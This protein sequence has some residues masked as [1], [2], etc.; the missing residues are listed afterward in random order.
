LQSVGIKTAF[1]EVRDPQKEIAHLY[2]M[3]DTGLPADQGESVSSNEKR[4]ILRQNKTGQ[5]SIWIPV[6]TTLVEE[7]FEAAWKA[8]A[9][10]YLEEGLLRNGLAEGWLFV[11]D[12]E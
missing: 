5:Q 3:F 4:Y 11:I 6:E 2:L 1:V 12:T 7:G 10:S 8:A 9:L